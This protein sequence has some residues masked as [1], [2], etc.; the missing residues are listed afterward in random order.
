MI[1]KLITVYDGYAVGTNNVHKIVEHSQNTFTMY[2]QANDI[3]FKVVSQEYRIEYV[4][5]F[6][7]DEVEQQ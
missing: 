6:K 2:N 1:K 3:L 4:K 7:K 5:G